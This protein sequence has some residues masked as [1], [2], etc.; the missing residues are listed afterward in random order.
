MPNNKPQ[1]AI[2]T[3]WRIALIFITLVPAFLT[4]LILRIGSVAWTVATGLWIFAFLAAYL[5][6]LPI[7]YKKL[8]YGISGDNIVLVSGTFYTR[9]CSIPIAG[10]QFTALVQ[11]WLDRFFGLSTLVINAAG[12]R[13]S[14][15]GLKTQDAK[16][17]AD[18]LK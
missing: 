10:I 17:L 7:R 12:G 14:I 11:S 1:P 15:P 13:I 18:L 6:Y 2:L 4:S 9:V 3:I 5:V 16:A 8:A